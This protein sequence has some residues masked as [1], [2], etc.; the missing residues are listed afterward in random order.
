MKPRR[1]LFLVK[2]PSRWAAH[3]WERAWELALMRID[4][5]PS[6]LGRTVVFQESLAVLNGA[7]ADGDGPRFELG[8]ITLMDFCSGAVNR[9]DCWQW[10]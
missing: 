9:G 4:G 10:W 3:D 6:T 1:R 2:H 8:L 5:M 7:F